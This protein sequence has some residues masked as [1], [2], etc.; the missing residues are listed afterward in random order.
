MI[1]AR[2]GNGFAVSGLSLSVALAALIAVIGAKRARR[3]RGERCERDASTQVDR[4]PIRGPRATEPPS[5]SPSEARERRPK[6]AATLMW[7]ARDR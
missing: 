5:W 1:A 7:G 4:G 6:A 3:A 2:S